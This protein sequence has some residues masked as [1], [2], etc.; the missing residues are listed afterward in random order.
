MDG[1]ILAAGLDI[2]E[3]RLEVR[4][5]KRDPGLVQDALTADELF[6]ALARGP[7]RLVVGEDRRGPAVDVG[8]DPGRHG[9]PYALLQQ[10]V[11]ER[12]AV[13]GRRPEQAGAAARGQGRR[14]VG[15][16]HRGQRVRA[17]VAEQRVRAQHR[18]VGRVEP[19]Q[20]AGHH[21]V[22]VAAGGQQ[23]RQA[24]G[25]AVQV[26]VGFAQPFADLGRG[27]RRQ[28]HLRS[29]ELADQVGLADRL[30]HLPSELSGGQ[31]QRV[32]IA[33]A[34]AN[35]PLLLLADE[36]TGN[37]DSATSEEILAVFDDLHERGRTIVMV[38]HEE[39]V[40]R[41]TK[42]QIHL[43]DG[44]VASDTRAAEAASGS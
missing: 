18:P 8:R 16:G 19:G 23:Q 15:A 12:H 41:H 27:Q 5:L 11:R 17:G 31:Q 6:D 35:D 14:R 37:L 1:A 28:R 29:R 2:R 21:D 9:G 34:L 33:R 10:R 25:A 38:T 3:L 7:A 39:H 24:A 30:K 4:F 22:R 42:R 43:L 36:P 20:H 13:L 26:G 40:A 32:A 44:R